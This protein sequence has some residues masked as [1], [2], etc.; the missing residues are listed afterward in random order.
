M[1]RQIRDHMLAALALIGAGLEGV[2]LEL[3]ECGL[4]FS[5]RHR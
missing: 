4:R 1:I 3:P 2:T 5:W